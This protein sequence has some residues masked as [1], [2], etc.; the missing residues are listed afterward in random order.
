MAQLVSSK[1]LQ[2]SL[3]IKS[4][5]ILSTATPI[6][7]LTI[8]AIVHI[9]HWMDSGSLVG[10]GLALQES[11]LIVLFLVRR[12]A[13]ESTNTPGAWIAAIIGSYGVLLLRPEGHI[14]LGA[15]ST[16]VAIQ[17]AGATLA[18]VTSLSLGRSFGIVAANRG[19]KT[20]GAYRFVRHPIY[21]SYLIGYI[22]YL[23]AAIS[24]LNVFIMVVSLTFQVRRMNAEEAVLK[25]DPQYSEYAERVR[26]RLVPGIY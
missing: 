18:I 24:I 13:K 22:A 16:S 26:Y 9:Q 5:N 14:I 15:E 2:S 3:G 6:S 8:F 7:L 10:L 1:R 21:A 20:E 23:L 11:V 17:L 12:Q 25:R 19:V 4:W